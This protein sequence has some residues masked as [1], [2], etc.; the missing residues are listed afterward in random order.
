MENTHNASTFQ[1]YDP[2]DTIGDT[3]PTAAKPPKKNKCGTFGQ[4]LLVVVAAVV[5]VYTAGAAAGA[6]GGLISG[7][8]A[9]AGALAG[10]GAITAGTGLGGAL[11]G[12]LGITGLA[13]GGTAASSAIFVTAGAIGGAVGSIASQAVG[14]ATGI[15]QKFSWNAVGMAAISALVS[16]GSAAK[17]GA[18]KNA[19]AAGLRGA[20]NSV[21][22]QGLGMA[23][24]MQTKFD[25]AGVATAGVGASIGR[26]AT[27]AVGI[28]FYDSGG[29]HWVQNSSDPMQAWQAGV[30][31]TASAIAATAT[32][33]AIA[34]GNFGDNFRAEIPNIIGNVI[35]TAMLNALRECFVAGTPVHTPEGPKPIETIQPGD[36]VWARHDGF[37]LSA[38]RARRVVQTF[39]TEDRS[40]FIVRL[41]RDDGTTETIRTTP[42]H[43]FAIGLP[44]EAAF[45]TS[46]GL[47]NGADPALANTI[48]LKLSNNEIAPLWKEAQHL[49]AG[50]RLLTFDGAI[51]RVLT[52][53]PDELRDTVFN[54]EVEDDHT[55]F[56]GELGTWVHNDSKAQRAFEAAR[57]KAHKE[58]RYAPELQLSDDE[59]IERGRINRQVTLS[60][61]E[62]ETPYYADAGRDLEAF[63]RAFDPDYVSSYAD[64]S[65][66]VRW[67]PK[68]EDF[69][70]TAG[71]VLH[72]A[73]YAAALYDSLEYS[74]VKPPLYNMT[75]LSQSGL[76]ISDGAGGSYTAALVPGTA[77]RSA[78]VLLQQTSAPS[79]QSSP[80]SGI[81]RSG[82][83]DM[84]AF[85]DALLK[86]YRTTVNDADQRYSR[87]E[88]AGEFAGIRQPRSLHRGNY[89]DAA[90]RFAARRFVAS[91]GLL[92]GPGQDIRINRRLYDP[93][94]T[95]SYRIPDVYIASIG[96][97]AD[98][99]TGPKTISNNRGQVSEMFRFSGA[100]VM[101]IVRPSST[102]GSYFITSDGRLHN[103]GGPPPGARIPVEVQIL[104]PSPPRPPRS[105]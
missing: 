44:L 51:L 20:A 59:Y 8:G 37:G 91:Q 66:P 60:G 94:G 72:D 21:A 10:A 50:D 105:K 47:A 12:G 67:G 7:T 27:E 102:G 26:M 89:I 96:R 57:D 103:Q 62:T 41:Q 42:A 93:A 3:A 11:A 81:G 6:I 71:K 17:F 32:R 58:G 25:W 101:E 46:V 28:G 86:V 77:E 85:A 104:P 84:N 48:N 5:S 64:V 19:L 69:Q 74:V 61:R 95:A 83:A 35:G 1:P 39:R 4:V 9:G 92:E 98:A 23:L 82:Y 100:S 53:A 79:G 70:Y 68:S 56:V 29:G 55:Y 76:E 2:S 30:V 16:G 90:A 24:G 54:F 38:V 14:V 40:T 52:A 34:G 36:L 80:A 49:E 18:G 78:R 97:I 88:A 65:E 15:Q 87:L 13:A 99:T 75:S 31:G 43:P 45:T 73:E 33:T 63:I 22:S